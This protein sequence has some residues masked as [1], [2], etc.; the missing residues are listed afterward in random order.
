DI[1][2]A[3]NVKAENQDNHGVQRCLGW[4]I[5]VLLELRRHREDSRSTHCPAAVRLAQLEVGKG[6]HHY[7]IPTRMLLR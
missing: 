7:F 2:T 1:V 4:L 6:R 3:S 5:P